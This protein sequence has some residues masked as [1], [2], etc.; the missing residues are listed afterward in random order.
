M[1]KLRKKDRRK[2]YRLSFIK[3]LWLAIIDGGPR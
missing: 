1:I 3:M 2:N